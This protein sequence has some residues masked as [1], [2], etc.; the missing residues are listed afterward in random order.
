MNTNVQSVFLA[1]I[2]LRLGGKVVITEKEIEAVGAYDGVDVTINAETRTVT[3]EVD[4]GGSL[5]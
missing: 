2:L 4:R 5:Q 3:M 1:A